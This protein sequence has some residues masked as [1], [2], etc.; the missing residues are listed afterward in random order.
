MK[1]PSPRHLVPD[2]GNSNWF[3]TRV[4][5][6]TL[7]QAKGLIQANTGCF[8]DQHKSHHITRLS[9]TSGSA[10]MAWPNLTYY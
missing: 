3:S 1:T 10:E 9:N 5:G 6:E 2:R 4:R 8:Q 7:I